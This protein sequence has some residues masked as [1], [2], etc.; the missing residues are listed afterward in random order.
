ML[1]LAQNQWN[2]DVRGFNP[3]GNHGSFL[4]V[5]TNS[6]LMIAGGEKTGIPRGRVVE[7][8]YDGLSFV[9]TVLR[10]MGKVDENNEPSQ[11][12]RQLRFRRFPGR[13]IRELVNP[14]K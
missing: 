9:P 6:T 7:E 5:S 2:F 4:R 8:P 12:L 13:V 10:L 3:G 14:S 1:V 11:E